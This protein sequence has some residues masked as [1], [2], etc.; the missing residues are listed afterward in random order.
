MNYSVASVGD[1]PVGGITAPR[2]QC[3]TLPPQWGV[4]ITVAD[5]DATAT[6]AVEHGGTLLF[7]PREIPGVGRFCLLQDPQGAVFYAITYA[8]PADGAA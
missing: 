2:K 1:A 6:Q 4:Y 7:P 5:V 8:A 3:A